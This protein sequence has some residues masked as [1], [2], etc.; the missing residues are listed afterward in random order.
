MIYYVDIDGTICYTPRVDGE[1]LYH[2]S[3][4]IRTRI[5]KINQLYDSGH[6]IVYWTA[7]G[8]STGI[9]HSEITEAQLN[10]WGAKY[11][12][13]KM[14]KPNYDVWVDD[15]ALDLFDFFMG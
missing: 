14:G 11:H 15:K 13:L 8:A 5:H 7:R 4:P 2:Q 9:D 1:N 6:T 3:V 10:D 12:E